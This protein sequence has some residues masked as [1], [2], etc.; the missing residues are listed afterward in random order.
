[1]SHSVTTSLLLDRHRSTS[2]SLC[3]LL[4]RPASRT[5]GNHQ[6]ID[7]PSIG[8]PERIPACLVCSG[9]NVPWHYGLGY[10]VLFKW[11]APDEEVAA[12]ERRW[13][14]APA[15]G[16]SPFLLPPGPDNSWPYSPHPLAHSAI[17][18]ALFDP[19][20]PPPSQPLPHTSL[21]LPSSQSSSKAMCS[22]NCGRRAGSKE[23]SYATFKTCLSQK[24]LGDYKGL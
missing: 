2:C 12:A 23:C 9:Q 4:V 3:T 18:P 21:S 1:M 11:L 24:G 22:R 6:F 14:D 8:C 7:C 16:A 19:L 10:Q 5:A 13:R 17:D 15:N 20:L